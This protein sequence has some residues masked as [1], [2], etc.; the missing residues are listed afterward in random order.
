MFSGGLHCS[1]LTHGSAQVLEWDEFW[2]FMHDLELGLDDAAIATLRQQADV[3]NDGSAAL[4]G[5]SVLAA[6]LRCF[7]LPRPGGRGLGGCWSV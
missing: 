6:P 2:R 5:L 1:V 3:N 7:C 4:N